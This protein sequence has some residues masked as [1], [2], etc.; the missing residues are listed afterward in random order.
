MKRFFLIA[1]ILGVIGMV[2][3]FP[4]NIA[5]VNATE[6]INANSCK[7]FTNYVVEKDDTL[8]DIAEEN[9]GPGYDS[10]Y[11]YIDEVMKSNHLESTDIRYGQMLILPY[12]TDAPLNNL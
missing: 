3:I 4:L 11:E 12:Y 2:L 9:M 8:W 1:V 6:S 7:Y 5:E 10:I